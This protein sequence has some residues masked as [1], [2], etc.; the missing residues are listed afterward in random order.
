MRNHIGWLHQRRPRR[1]ECNFPRT[2]PKAFTTRCSRRTARARPHVQLV[3]EI[4]QSLSDGQ[5]LRYKHA[6]ERLLLQ[7]GITFNV[8]GDTAGTERIFPF[9]LI[10]RIV[11][12]RRMGPHR[13]RPQAAHPRAQRLHRRH[14]SRPED[15]QGRRHSRRSGH[16][17]RLLPQAVPRPE[18]AVAAS[19]AT[20]PAPTWCATATANTTSWRT[21]C[22]C[23]PASPTCW[24]IARC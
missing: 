24:R 22:A 20:S 11:P 17:R 4:I 15:P 6:A 13:A 19:G 9:D 23:P 8:Y 12:R 21:T 16:L 5:L 1:G 14:L 3:L 7:L 18:S 10:P 2:R